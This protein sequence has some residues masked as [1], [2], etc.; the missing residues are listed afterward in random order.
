MCGDYNSVIGMDKE[1]PVSRFTTR[2]R[3]TRFTPAAGEGTLCG[4]FVETD[5]KTGLAV[6]AEPIRVGG[7]L[8]DCVPVLS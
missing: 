6:R 5:N 3:G 7:L 2:M 8:P 1:E 4:V